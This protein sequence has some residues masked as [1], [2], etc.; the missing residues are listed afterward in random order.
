MY[1]SQCNVYNQL[2]AIY[3]MSRSDSQLYL[4][5]GTVSKLYTMDLGYI[6]KCGLVHYWPVWGNVNDVVGGADLYDGYN[7]SF[8]T[9]RF[10]NASSSIDFSF[11]YYSVPNGVYFNANPFTVTVWFNF[12]S[13]LEHERIFDF[14]VA[15]SSNEVILEYN[16]ATNF[17]GLVFWVYNSSGLSAHVIS[18]I[19]LQ[20]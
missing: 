6:Y 8:G 12:K 15:E 9:N 18:N 1:N 4:K 17:N 19:T 11:G 13:L 7:V 10:G 14:A 3:L 20:V 5:S 16:G 2:A